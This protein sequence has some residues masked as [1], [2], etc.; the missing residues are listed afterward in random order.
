M[1]HSAGVAS[2]RLVQSASDT[3]L[4]ISL[5]INKSKNKG[6]GNTKVHPT[7]WQD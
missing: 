3:P 5:A 2:L 1:H 7:P 4:F 6:I